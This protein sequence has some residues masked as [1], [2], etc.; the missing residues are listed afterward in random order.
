MK[1]ER[2]SKEALN[3]LPNLTTKEPDRYR[4]LCD[5]M[6]ESQ[7]KDT[8]LIVPMDFVQ[9]TRNIRGVVKK[10]EEYEA[11]RDSIAKDGLIQP[12]V[13]QLVNDKPTLIAGYR[14]WTACLELGWTRIPATAKPTQSDW[15]VI[16]ICENLLRA[17]L[18]GIKYAEAIAE[19][20]AT[21][22][23][24]THAQLA[25]RIGLKDRGPIGFYLKAAAWPDDVKAECLEKNLGRRAILEIA[26]KKESN[27]ATALPAMVKGDDIKKEETSPA[28][29]S[30]DSKTM[31]DVV[32]SIKQ[33]LILSGVTT[34]SAVKVAERLAGMQPE[35]RRKIA[36]S[37]LEL[38]EPF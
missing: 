25:A 37:I 36:R 1:R 31:N 4:A 11:L 34:K 17:N 14:R 38:D 16:Q 23:S 21:Y 30:L 15:R 3:N 13:I 35:I 8:I 6:R 12:V 24:D 10:D 5:K 9:L 19:L 2:G 33:R 27:D 20:A 22:P 32:S 28:P 18:P 7:D 26:R 29:S